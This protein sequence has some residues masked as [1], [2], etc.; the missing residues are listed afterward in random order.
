M[1][2]ST[3]DDGSPLIDLEC[4]FVDGQKFAAVTIDGE[5]PKLARMMDSALDMLAMLHR[6]HIA[7]IDRWPDAIELSVDVAA[8]L[9]EADFNPEEDD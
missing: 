6:V 7:I 8:L 2:D 1:R 9:R 5:F 3:D 4:R